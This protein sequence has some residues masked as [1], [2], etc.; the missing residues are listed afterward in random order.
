MSRPRARA[1]AK[2][3]AIPMNQGT[4]VP[5]L[6]SIAFLVTVMMVFFRFA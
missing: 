1:R 6:V 4:A 5:A 3:E 2:V